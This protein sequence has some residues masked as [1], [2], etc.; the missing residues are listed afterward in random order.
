MK[1]EKEQQEAHPLDESAHKYMSQLSP[2]DL[3][4]A[5][6]EQSGA[7][8]IST[9]APDFRDKCSINIR[10]ESLGPCASANTTTLSGKRAMRIY[11]GKR[12][13]CA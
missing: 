5:C 1:A 6:R 9:K 12:R 2:S 7:A 11:D 4:H 13:A 8:L 3:A 10:S